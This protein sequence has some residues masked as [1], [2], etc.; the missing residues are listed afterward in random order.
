M[1]KLFLSSSFA[2]VAD[3][4]VNFAHED[5]LGK[6]V[7]FIP[8]ASINEEVKFY[9]DSAKAALEKIGLIIDELELTTASKK[10]IENKLKLNDYIYVSGGN[11]FFLLQELKRTGADKTI[12][13][14]IKLGKMYIGESAGSIILSP[15]IEYVKD[16]DDYSRASDLETFSALNIIDFYPVPHY[17]NFP[18]VEAVEKIISKF[19]SD[20]SLCPITNAQVIVVRGEVVRVESI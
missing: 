19:N 11:T 15:N 3:L 18:F 13:E 10:E 2:D 6:T 14:Q 7:T 5:L 9:V 12:I 16:M 4:F 8:T 20:F 1:K 17:T